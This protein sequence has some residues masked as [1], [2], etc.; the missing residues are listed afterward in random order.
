M[1]RSSILAMPVTGSVPRTLAEPDGGLR[2]GR[3]SA[4]REVSTAAAHQEG[5]GR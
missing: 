2:G 5:H 3:R 1:A 4:V